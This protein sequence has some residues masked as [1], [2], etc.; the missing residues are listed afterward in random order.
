MRWGSS[1]IHSLGL[2]YI[3]AEGRCS[4]LLP[5]RKGIWQITGKKAALVAMGLGEGGCSAAG[6]SQGKKDRHRSNWLYQAEHADEL[7]PFLA[8]CC[9]E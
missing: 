3:A 1:G 2:H 9:P 5:V 8:A 6:R 4:F 7:S